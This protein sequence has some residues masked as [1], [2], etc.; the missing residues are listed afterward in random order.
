MATTLFPVT[1]PPAH[2]FGHNR[3]QAIA[4]LG[5]ALDHLSRTSLFLTDSAPNNEAIHILNRL[6]RTI[7]D[8]REQ[9]AQ[10]DHWMKEATLN[11]TNQAA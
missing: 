7:F 11:H 6:R 8:E 2:R 9:P 4:I 1:C 5:R 3:A 10:L